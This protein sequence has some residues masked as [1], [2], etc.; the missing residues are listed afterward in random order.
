MV[1][2]LAKPEVAYAMTEVKSVDASP[3]RYVFTD[4]EGGYSP[5]TA[6]ILTCQQFICKAIS[7]LAG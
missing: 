7:R 2:G 6:G 3:S 5:M 4:S 1:K